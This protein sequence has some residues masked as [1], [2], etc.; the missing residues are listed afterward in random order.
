M[1]ESHFVLLKLSSTNTVVVAKFLSETEDVVEVE[2]PLNVSTMFEG[3]DVEIVCAKYAPFA[4]SNRVRISKAAIFAVA[5]P[6]P[7]LIECYTSY[8]EQ[9]GDDL[10]DSMQSFMDSSKG[11]RSASNA[12]LWDDT[13]PEGT[14]FH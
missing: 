2:Y 6:S 12:Q 14:V 5:E 13:V 9:Y 7:S 3:D 10:E 1:T 11:G 8:I 4:V